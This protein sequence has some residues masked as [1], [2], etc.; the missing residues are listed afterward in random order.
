MLKKFQNIWQAGKMEIPLDVSLIIVRET[1][2]GCSFHQN[3]FPEAWFKGFQNFFPEAFVLQSKH[4]KN[5]LTLKHIPSLGNLEELC[6]IIRYMFWSL[7]DRTLV[8]KGHFL[9]LKGWKGHPALV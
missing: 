6:I 5:M 2:E 4:I 7:V 9:T 1:C 3:L 8:I